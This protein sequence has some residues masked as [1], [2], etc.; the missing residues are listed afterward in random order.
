M[1]PVYTLTPYLFKTYFIIIS[2]IW[3]QFSRMIY[4]LGGF[5]SKILNSYFFF[6]FRS[7]TP[8]LSLGMRIEGNNIRPTGRLYGILLLINSTLPSA[9]PIPL[10]KENPSPFDDQHSHFNRETVYLPLIRYQHRPI[11]PSLVSLKCTLSQFSCNL[12]Q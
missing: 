6:N 12:L 2:P 7:V 9:N 5:P 8:I 4:S 3:A 10:R 1:N 11:W